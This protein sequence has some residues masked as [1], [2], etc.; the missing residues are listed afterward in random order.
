VTQSD[1]REQLPPLVRAA[2]R[3]ESDVVEELLRGGAHPNES[4]DEGWTAL[5]AAAA[6]DHAQIVSRLLQA[7]AA[8]DPRDGEGFTPLMGAAKAGATVI[9]ALLNAGADPMA[10]DPNTG[11]LPLYWFADHGNLAGIRLLLDAGADIDAR[12][13]PDG[14]TALMAATD[15][16]HV[17]CVELLLSA[18]AD[19]SLTSDGRTAAAMAADRGYRE[20]A[21][22]LGAPPNDRLGRISV[23][24]RSSRGLDARIFATFEP[25]AATSASTVQRL[26]PL[27]L[28]E[29]TT[30]LG[31][32]DAVRS[33]T[34]SVG[35]EE[36]VT[37]AKEQ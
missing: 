16:C 6:F 5:H 35:G 3:G 21:A 25:I 17:E 4:D 33:L 34:I 8:V 37:S 9:A 12:D 7:G 24:G 27:E 20:L 13:S 30:R 19:A 1:W 23:A 31:Q 2:A 10:Q 15:H 32:C 14:E 18:G 22:V 36:Q 11:W 28:R 26:G 29:T